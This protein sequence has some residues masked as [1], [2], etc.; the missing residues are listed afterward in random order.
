MSTM[1]SVKKKRSNEMDM[2]HGSMLDKILLFALPLAAGS[3]LQQLFNSV[4][5]AVVG[6]FASSQALAA[7]G[8]NSSV[9]AL[10]VNLFV[11]ISVGANVLIASY[12][13]QGRKEKIQDAVHT[14]AMVAVIS[15][16]VLL[17]LVMLLARPILTLMSTPAD[18]IDQAVLYLRIYSLGMP[19]IM[20]YNFGAAILR[21][22]GDTK[23][24]LY[25]L[26]V[27]GVLNAC[28]NLLLVVV[29][30]LD[31]AGVAIAT[32][33][34]NIV[35]SGMVTYFLLHEDEMIR[36]RFDKLKIHKKELSAIIKI[37]IPAGLQGVVF[38]LSNV[39]IQSGINSFGS[40][41]VAGS[42]AALNFEYIAYFVVSAFA[43]TAVTFT[44]QNYGA[45]QYDR[46]KKAFRLSM[47]AGVVCSGA[48]DI[49]F[50]LGRGIFIQFFSVDPAVIEYA[51]IRMMS[52]LLFEWL[53][54]TYEIGG[55]ALRGMGYSMTPAALTILGTCVIRVIWTLVICHS[56][57]RDFG[58]LLVVYPVTWVITGTLVLSA[59]F[60]IRR[61]LFKYAE[62]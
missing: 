59:Y 46:C 42:A 2:L 62:E 50:I 26:I 57:F 5:V 4:D 60:I 32:V 58:L 39:C 17:L 45:R 15:G 14:A 40:D 21:S 22:R 20:I 43:Q 37:G 51:N 61:R 41:A 16:G 1:E 31:V 52:I 18:V 53:S 24:P 8:S 25:C 55:S 30:H 56:R 29:F 11:G 13:G 6:R 47:M 36:L 48:L 27:S 3:V 38:S 12:I 34:A 10:F 7:V 33:T 28:L 54:C 44:S 49:I 35:S 19:F 23:R 9:I